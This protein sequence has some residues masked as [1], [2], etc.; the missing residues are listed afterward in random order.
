VHTI[1]DAGLRSP[2]SSVINS[3]RHFLFPSSFFSTQPAFS[4]FP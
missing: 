4:A 1:S 2:V 3:Q